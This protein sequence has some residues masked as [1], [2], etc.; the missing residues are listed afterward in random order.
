MAVKI[1][2]SLQQQ[3]FEQM[4]ATFPDEGGGFLLGLIDG[5]DT[6]IQD[7][8]Q[9][10]NVFETEEQYHR[11]AMTPQNWTNMED[12]AEEQGLQLIGYYH[13]HPDHPAIPSEFDRDHALPNFIYIITSVLDGKSA[14][15]L[16]WLLS[17]DRS[18]FNELD[19]V[20][21]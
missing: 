2:S 21:T 13:S 14:K 15:Q 18:K 5:E 9:V 12:E 1:S 17:E 7:V 4:E 11:Y 16:A 19:L 8:I 20:V 6:I 3:I 10:E